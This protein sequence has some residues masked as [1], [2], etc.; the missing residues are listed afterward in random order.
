MITMNVS[1]AVFSEINRDLLDTGSALTNAMNPVLD[2]RPILDALGSSTA[3]W[4]VTSLTSTGLV[5]TLPGGFLL[6]ISGSGIGPVGSLAELEAAIRDGFA[7]GTLNTA[8][9][10]QG[11]LEFLR[12]ELTPTG[13]LATSGN[14]S[15]SLTGSL[16]NTFSRFQD[17]VDLSRL[18]DVGS[19]YTMTTAARAQV[20]NDLSAFG[21]TG[22]TAMDGATTL[23][24]LDIAPTA[25]TLTLGGYELTITGAFPTNMG[26]IASLAFDA[27]VAMIEQGTFTDTTWTTNLGITGLTLTDPAGAVLISATGLL[28]PAHDD[29]VLIDGVDATHMSGGYFDAYGYGIWFQDSP[30]DIWG[31]PFSAFIMGTLGNDHLESGRGDALVYGFDGNDYIWGWD[32]SDTL[33]G[34]AGNDTIL[35]DP[36]NDSL[37]GG[38]GNDALVGGLGNDLLDGGA[39][40]D[41]AYFTGTAAAAVNLN[42][43]AAQNTGYGLDTLISIEHVTSGNG[44][45]RLTG[46]ALA[47]SLSAGLG[48]DA[49]NG[50]AGNDLLVGGIGSDAFVFNTALSAGNIDRITDFSVVDDTIRLEN[51]IFTGLAN[52]VLTAAAFV[53][54]ATGL[55]GDASDRII[56]ET[57]TGNLF[58]D[59]DGTGAAARVQF[60]HLNAGLALTN[61]DF[62]VI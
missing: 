45:D 55:A 7:S 51:A 31:N 23:F 29:I 61:A 57:D 46:N 44:N 58:F 8:V 27:Y 49:L 34:G 5:E 25:I 48:N 11:G 17:L 26:M 21:L 24:S 43:T 33:Y 16:V 50:G 6:T 13:Y 18:A 35:G 15:V 59:A 28:T 32:G 36:G 3:A 53:A 10:Q 52:G 47:N 56:F 22:F 9:W 2:H 39:G 42:L 14:Q 1:S 4:T 40:V 62:L 41:R 12:L 38:D 37:L 54:N 60:A 20:F 30:V 19:L